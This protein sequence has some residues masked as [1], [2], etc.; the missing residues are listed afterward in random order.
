MLLTLIH[1]F[2]ETNNALDQSNELI[3]EL[4]LAGAPTM[5]ENFRFNSSRDS[6]SSTERLNKSERSIDV[7]GGNYER[8]MEVKATRGYQ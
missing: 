7:D 3:I 6:F 8:D 4:K 5:T 1:S 2:V